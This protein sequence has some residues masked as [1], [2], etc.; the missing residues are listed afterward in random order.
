MYMSVFFY[1]DFNN[2]YI[3]YIF[4]NI[5]IIGDFMV[6][7]KSNFIVISV[8]KY[9]FT[10]LCL[11]FILTLIIFSDTN[12]EAAKYGL[13]LWTTSVVPSLFPFFVATE[14]LCNTNII[15][16]AGKYLKNIIGK[17]F[18]VPGEGAIALMIG[19]ICGYPAGAKVIVNLKERE[20]LTKEEAER[21]LAFTNNS[22]P[23][24][25]LGTIGISF[26]NNKKIGYILLFTHIVACL[27]V[28]Y[29]F[30]SWKKDKQRIW[31][32]YKTD[33]LKKNM[34][35]SEFGEILGMSIKKSI[36]TI[37]NIGGFIVIFSVIISILE[38]SH[39]FDIITSFT[40]KL[41]FQGEIIVGIL[42]GILELTNGAKAVSVLGSSNLNIA[43]LAFIIGFGGISVMLQ[44]YSIIAKEKISIKPYIYGK[45]LQ[46][47]LAFSYTLIFLTLF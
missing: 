3:K 14:L 16:I 25:I 32:I 18:N 12:L 42:K 43:I 11:V 19:I 37:L 33:S 10:V 21:L 31:N 41:G 7:T 23:L 34:S 47:I 8:K 30:R 4:L 22:G 35:I 45:L 5:Y 6:K 36:G 1:L 2:L 40:N 29:I 39:I 44:V 13:A 24:F 38:T 46:G 27:T 15:Y 26:L 20:V 28:G 17:L 9:F